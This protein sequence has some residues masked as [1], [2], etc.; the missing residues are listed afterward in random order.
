MQNGMFAIIIWPYLDNTF[1][2]HVA[3]RMDRL[4]CRMDGKAKSWVSA[5][6]RPIDQQSKYISDV[7]AWRLAFLV[8]KFLS[9][10][11][12]V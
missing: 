5:F 7:G 11:P 12:N 10:K 3:L 2:R 9:Q 4:R 8:A 6:R 1:G